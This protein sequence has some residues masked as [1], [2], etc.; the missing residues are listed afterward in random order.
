VLLHRCYRSENQAGIR[1]HYGEGVLIS[2]HG[3]HLGR[4]QVAGLRQWG[5]SLGS[6]TIVRKFKNR[7]RRAAAQQ[8][9]LPS[10]TSGAHKLVVDCSAAT[11]IPAVRFVPTQEVVIDSSGDL[12]V[13]QYCTTTIIK[14][15]QTQS[16]ISGVSV[17]LLDSNFQP[18]GCFRGR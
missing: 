15:W 13:S 3:G 5:R 8:I 7:C 2:A 14:N 16:I 6:Q 1:H 4:E 17:Q 11:P 12:A 18:N 10:K 9:S